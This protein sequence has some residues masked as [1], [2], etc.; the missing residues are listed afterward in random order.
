[1]LIVLGSDCTAVAFVELKRCFNNYQTWYVESVE[2]KGSLLGGFWTQLYVHVFN[3]LVNDFLFLN[4][5]CYLFSLC[6]WICII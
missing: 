5:K 3:I 4:G 2:F 6:A 1:M